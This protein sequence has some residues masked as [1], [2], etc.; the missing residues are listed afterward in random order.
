MP[1][2]CDSLGTMRGSELGQAT[3]HIISSCGHTSAEVK[4]LEMPPIDFC[5]DAERHSWVEKHLP[6]H[7]SVS[8][9]HGTFLGGLKW[10]EQELHSL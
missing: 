8:P 4:P 10:Q 6:A 5:K 2:V 1:G 9:R 7:P 3:A